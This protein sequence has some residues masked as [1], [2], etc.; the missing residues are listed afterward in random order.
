MESLRSNGVSLLAHLSALPQLRELKLM[1]SFEV[2][3][4]G[5]KALAQVSFQP[6]FKSLGNVV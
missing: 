4:A 1:G 5:I 6:R 3:A 2:S